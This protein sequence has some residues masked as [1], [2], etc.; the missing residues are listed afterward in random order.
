MIT[1]YYGNLPLLVGYQD[2][3]HLSSK[4]RQV[5]VCVGDKWYATWTAPF[6]KA[7]GDRNQIIVNVCDHQ[8]ETAPETTVIKAWHETNDKHAWRFA[9]EIP[10]PAD[11]TMTVLE[12]FEWY[13]RRNYRLQGDR[14]RR[15]GCYLIQVST[16]KVV[17]QLGRRWRRRRSAASLV[18]TISFLGAGNEYGG[19]WK[20]IVFAVGLCG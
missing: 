14:K 4:S 12:E 6:L 2:G 8:F 5:G 19:L 13:T 18:L 11:N 16:Q 17:A 7:Y 15:K 1:D 10:D 3:S 9:V 20:I